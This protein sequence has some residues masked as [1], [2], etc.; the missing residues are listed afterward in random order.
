MAS[1]L[2]CGAAMR[3]VGPWIPIVLS[4]SFAACAVG[5]VDDGEDDG[6]DVSESA[7]CDWAT[8]QGEHP[9]V[10]GHWYRL[11]YFLRQDMT[12]MAVP[13]SYG[14]ADRIHF[15]DWWGTG[16]SSATVY[17]RGG[18]RSATGYSFIDAEGTFNSCV[19]RGVR[20]RDNVWMDLW[21]RYFSNDLDH[22]D[23]DRLWL[24]TRFDPGTGPDDAYL[25]DSPTPVYPMA[26]FRR[27]VQDACG[28]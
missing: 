18:D 4:C 19:R 20:L 13:A 10:S 25:H 7:G 15:G 21:M 9:K 2:E 27:C 23:D 1:F 17:W 28:V 22:A 11:A 3:T 24:W 8:G 26:V 14:G 5:D 6:L 16:T 12:H